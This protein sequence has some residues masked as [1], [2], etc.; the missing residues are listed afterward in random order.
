MGK[1][2]RDEEVVWSPIHVQSKFQIKF[3]LSITIIVTL[4]AAA[5]LRM[6]EK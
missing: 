3:P 2:D 1:P 6:T 4:K 5:L